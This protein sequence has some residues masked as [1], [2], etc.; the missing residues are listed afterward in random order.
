M[1][2]LPLFERSLEAVMEMNKKRWGC[3]AGITKIAITPEGWIYPCSR[4]V[5]VVSGKESQY[6]LGHLT[7]G[8]RP[9]PSPSPFQ[10]GQWAR[11]KCARCPI[12]DFCTGGCPAVNLEATGSIYEPPKS[13]CAEMG[14]WLNALRKLPFSLK[15]RPSKTIC[16][17]EAEGR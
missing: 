11:S 4:F 14:A 16:S 5:S 15:G 10:A 3:A 17:V 1:L 6:Q 12:A 2:R 7:Q 8:W 9:L 13:L